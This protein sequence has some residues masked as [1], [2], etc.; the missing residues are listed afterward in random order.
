[1]NGGIPHWTHSFLFT[2]FSGLK[3]CLWNPSREVGDVLLPHSPA[4]TPMFP[5]VVALRCLMGF[6]GGSA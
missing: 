5:G 4:L 2:Q 6:P 1:M 3:K